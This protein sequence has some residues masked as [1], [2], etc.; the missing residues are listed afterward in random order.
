MHWCTEITI[1]VGYISSQFLQ[2]FR[3]DDTHY[4]PKIT[5]LGFFVRCLHKS[6]GIMQLQP[7]TCCKVITA[8]AHLHNICLRENMP[9]PD[10][11]PADADDNDDGEY[12]N[13]NQEPNGI[14][15]RNNVIRNYFAQ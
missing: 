7:T 14:A 9:I 13:V 1:S 8:C 2:Q 4:V 5:V 12:E 15:A 3:I 6:G 10:D 11:L